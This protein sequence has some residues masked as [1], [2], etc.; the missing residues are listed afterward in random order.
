M[1]YI[2]LECKS[3]KQLKRTCAEL[4]SLGVTAFCLSAKGQSVG[5]GRGVSFYTSDKT[6]THGGQGICAEGDEKYYKRKEFIVAV[7]RVL[8]ESE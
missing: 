3:V 4:E 1:S 2:R 7:K 8:G 6:Y 5:V